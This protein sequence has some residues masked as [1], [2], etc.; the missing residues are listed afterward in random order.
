[1]PALPLQFEICA[2]KEAVCAKSAVSPP[3]LQKTNPGGRLSACGHCPACALWRADGRAYKFC[4]QCWSGSACGERDD[5]QQPALMGCG[6]SRAADTDTT[7]AA[8]KLSS[9]PPS[10]AVALPLAATA[11]TEVPTTGATSEEQ[12]KRNEEEQ[13]RKREEQRAF[14]ER[15]RAERDSQQRASERARDSRAALELEYVRLEKKHEDAVASRRRASEVKRGMLDPSALADLTSATIVTDEPAA[16]HSQSRLSNGLPSTGSLARSLW[17]P[18]AKPRKS[19]LRR[20]SARTPSAT[21][22]FSEENDLSTPN[23]HHEG[24]VSRRLH[25]SFGGE[26]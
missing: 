13:L 16:S 9:T 10:P 24:K 2:S 3:K 1:M 19:A 18:A 21:L 17:D 8:P 22:L 5:A 7:D 14:R 11:A 15:V 12:H 25:V 4:G 23:K 6:A 26:T 20:S